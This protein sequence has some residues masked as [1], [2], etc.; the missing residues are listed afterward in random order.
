[1]NF[2]KSVEFEVVSTEDAPDFIQIVLL[3]NNEGLGFSIFQDGTT[4]YIY[5]KSDSVPNEYITTD[6]DVKIKGGKYVATATV[7]SAVNSVNS[8]RLIKLNKILG[9]DLTLKEKIK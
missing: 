4:T 5:Y 9:K 2:G 1:M 7:Q 8:D 6:L 3:D